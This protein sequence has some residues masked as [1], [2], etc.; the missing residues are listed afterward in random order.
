MEYFRLKIMQVRG[1]LNSRYVPV[2]ALLGNQL[3]AKI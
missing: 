2:A 3:P 1:Y